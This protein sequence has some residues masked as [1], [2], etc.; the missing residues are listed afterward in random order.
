[1]PGTVDS[2]E[3]QRAVIQTLADEIAMKIADL[4]KI[5]VEPVDVGFSGDISFEIRPVE[6]DQR[7][8]VFC[9]GRGCTSVKYSVDGLRVDVFGEDDLTPIHSA[10]WHNDDLEGVAPT[11]SHGSNSEHKPS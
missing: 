7:L 1:M 10:S 9:K 8:N 2:P 3:V 11:Q 6:D 5:I 4:R